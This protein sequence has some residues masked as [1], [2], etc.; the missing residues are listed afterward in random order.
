MD[1]KYFSREECH[2]M[3]RNLSIPPDSFLWIARYGGSFPGWHSLCYQRNL[4]WNVP[5]KHKD[6]IKT[7]EAHLVT[8]VMGRLILQLLVHQWGGKWGRKYHETDSAVGS[9][10]YTDLSGYYWRCF[11]AFLFA[12]RCR[13]GG[14]YHSLWA[15]GKTSVY[16]VIP[17]CHAWSMY[18]RDVRA[19][20]G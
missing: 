18:Q 12:G 8:L 3:R 10:H 17:A 13:A 9:G 15:S 14:V 6:I 20:R 4:R 19:S 16:S 1:Y 5:V 2:E 7:N 11:S